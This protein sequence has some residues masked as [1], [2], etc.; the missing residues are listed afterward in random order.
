MESS[1]AVAPI[2]T[3]N[4]IEHTENKVS[5]HKISSKGG[6]NAAIFIISMHKNK[7]LSLSEFVIFYFI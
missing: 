3:E 1:V 7:R 6:W 2:A 4:G 5:H